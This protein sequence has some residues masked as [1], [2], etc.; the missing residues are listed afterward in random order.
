MPAEHITCKEC[1]KIA[2]EV[3]RMKIGHDFMVK[4]RCGHILW[5]KALTP[6]VAEEE[7]T[8][9]DGATLYEFQKQTL[10][11]AL[12][13]GARCLIAHEQG[14]GKTV[15]ALAVLAAKSDEMLPAI[16]I[17]KNKL[18]IQWMKQILNW[19]PG[20]VYPQVIETSKDF[21]LPTRVHI[22]SYDLLRRMPE[23]FFLKEFK[24]VIIDECQHIKNS[25]SKRTNGVR[26]LTANAKHILALSG[27]PIKNN[28]AEYFPI[29]NILHPERF[30]SKE[31][32]VHNFV[33]TYWN[34]R[35]EVVGG[36]INPEYFRE[37]TGDFII[38]YEQEEV[39]P[40]L[41]QMSRHFQ[42]FDIDKDLRL[43]YDATAQELA[44]FL[45]EKGD[46]A[47]N[48]ANYSTIIAYLTKMRQITGL[49][50][51]EACV[52]Y[53]SDLLLNTNQKV[54]IFLH[55]HIAR[56]LLMKKLNK[57]CVDGNFEAP[58]SIESGTSMQRG[59]E[60][61]QEFISNPTKRILVLGT[62]ASGEG[63]D[64]LQG[65]CSKMIILERQWNPA[66]EEQAEKRLH[67][68]GQK[69]P[70]EVEYMIAVGTIDE[71]FTELVERKRQVV[72]QTLGDSDQ[73]KW[74]ETETISALCEAIMTK[75][76]GKKWQLY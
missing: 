1:G 26:L 18:S 39:L 3:S 60:I 42:Y 9:K 76:G 58:L 34:G 67:R 5:T 72:K 27:T 40:D 57:L 63:L 41:P 69:N 12:N 36:L 44:N 74:D 11:F 6:I 17:C 49:A 13:A 28:A 37:K 19:L 38:R 24:T 70:V 25:S 7:L 54:V 16:I 30:P 65:S 43:A 59:E 4:L 23:S 52:D 47:L 75:R 71:M 32:Y 29:L 8:G 10:D 15:C 64:G 14:L 45:E 55:H 31:Y 35:K 56:D 73:V 22:I 51:V 62:L 2:L 66:N 61:K 46:G 21:I 20:E 33:D 50:K 48:F 53:V 68:I